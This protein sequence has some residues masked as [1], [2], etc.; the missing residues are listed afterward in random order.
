MENNK[1]EK[2]ETSFRRNKKHILFLVGFTIVYLAI[3]YGYPYLKN[4]ICNIF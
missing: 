3:T 2:R 1:T 4:I